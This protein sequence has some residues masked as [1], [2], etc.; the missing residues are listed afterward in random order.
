MNDNYNGHCFC[1]ETTFNI[2]GKP[3]LRVFCHCTICQAFN[4]APFADITLFRPE[5]VEMPTNDTVAYKAHTFP[6]IVQRGTCVKCSKPA[7]E[8]LTV[9]KKPNIVIVPSTNICNNIHL[10]API[11]H[12]F[13]QSRVADIEDDLPKISGYFNSQFLLIHKLVNALRR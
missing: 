6:P 9:L 13:Y 5:H 7:I 4:Q 2:I 11:M 8:Y 1:G 3:L 12:I 10:P